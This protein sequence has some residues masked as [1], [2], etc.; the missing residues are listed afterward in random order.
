MARYK[1]DERK[2]ALRETRQALL[3]AAAEAFARDGYTAANINTISL[4]A[5]FA[6]GTVYNHFPNK[7]GLMLALIDDIAAAHVSHI[8]DRVRAEPDPA[9]RL[10]RFFEAGF[11]FVARHPDQC[12]VLITTLHGPDDGFRDHLGQAYLPLFQLVG[13]EIVAPGVAGGHF[14]PVDPAAMAA[15]LMNIYLGSSSQVDETGRPRLAAEQV[16]D[17]AWHALRRQAVSAPEDS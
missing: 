15:L 4:A 5:G 2:K 14:R 9:R 13:Q 3:Q 1:E 16:A 6:K 12:R 8:V 11:D 10:A 7:R 17:F